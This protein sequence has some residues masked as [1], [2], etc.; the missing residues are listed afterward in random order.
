MPI[1]FGIL[2]IGPLPAND[3]PMV[4]G[5]GSVCLWA[6]SLCPL[7]AIHMTAG[8]DLTDPLMLVI[9]ANSLEMKQ[10]ASG[11]ELGHG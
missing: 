5:H 8:S 11:Y 7:M 10:H 6:G 4:S 3:Q 1:N 9:K 2:T